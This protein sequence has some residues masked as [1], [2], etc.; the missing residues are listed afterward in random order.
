VHQ[1]FTASV[2]AVGPQQ[3]DEF[4]ILWGCD[5]LALI[6]VQGAAFRPLQ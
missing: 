3:A 5:N 2:G 1:D 6:T 4:R